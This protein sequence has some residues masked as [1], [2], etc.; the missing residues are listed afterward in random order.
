MEEP[1]TLRFTHGRG[2][3]SDLKRWRGSAISRVA[4]DSDE[5]MRPVEEIWPVAGCG[6]EGDD[7]SEGRGFYSNHPGPIREVY[8]VKE[9]ALGRSNA[10]TTLRLRLASPGATSQPA[11][12]LTTIRWGASSA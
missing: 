12:F 1:Q 2:P 10:S 9:E 6:L 7:Y 11:G 4:P 8:L 5:P 3:G